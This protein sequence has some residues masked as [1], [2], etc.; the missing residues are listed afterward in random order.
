[1]IKCNN[2]GNEKALLLTRQN[3]KGQKGIFH[4]EQC[5]GTLVD[6]VGEALVEAICGGEAQEQGQ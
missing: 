1:M 2:C 6:N 4:C 3:P 5:T